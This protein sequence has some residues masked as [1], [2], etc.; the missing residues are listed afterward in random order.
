MSGHR[1]VRGPGARG[2]AAARGWSGRRGAVR[3]PHRRAGPAHPGR[4]G[5]RRAPVAVVV[6]RRGRRPRP[7]L[8]PAA[9]QPRPR[10]R[11]RSTSRVLGPD[12]ELETPAPAGSWWPRTRRGGSTSRASPRRSTTSPSTCTPPAAAWWPRSTT[13]CAARRRPPRAWSGWPR[14]TGPPTGCTWRGSRDGPGPDPARRQP[15]RP[16]R[17]RRRRVAGASGTF[18]PTG[19]DP[20]TVA[21][22]TIKSVDVSGVLPAGEPSALRLRSRVPSSPHCARPPAAR[23]RLRVPGGRRWWGPPPPR[24][25]PA[26]GPPSS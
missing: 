23:P 11:R 12:G 25:W 2:N 24:S 3:V 10:S 8:H 5:L 9:R 18:T 17:R 4:L 22:G 13:P 14:P 15:V 7:L 1:A 26:P 21:P 20:I 19:L 16:S 6:R